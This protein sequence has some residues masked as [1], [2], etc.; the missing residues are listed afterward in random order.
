[1]KR[2]FA[3]L[4]LS[5]FLLMVPSFDG[6]VQGSS[7]YQAP[8]GVYSYLTWG[9]GTQAQ[10][11]GSTVTGFASDSGIVYIQAA[12]EGYP[13]RTIA[14]L[15]GCSAWTI[16]VPSTV[17]RI[18][19]GAFEG[20]DD[21]KIVYFLGDRPEGALP[22]DVP[23]IHLEGTSGWDG[24]DVLQLEVYES[25]GSSFD[26][27]V[28]DGKAV[29]HALLSGTEISIPSSTADGIPFRAIGD[30][31]FRDSDVTSV[32]IG[33]GVEEIGVRAFYGC[34]YLTDVVYPSTLETLRDECFRDCL[35]LTSADLPDVAFIGF[36]AFR[37]CKA[38]PYAVIPDSVATLHDGAFYLCRAVRT[39]E[40]GERITTIPPRCFGYCDSIT[41]VELPDRVTDIGRSAFYSCISLESIGL[42]N[43]RSIGDDAF[44]GCYLLGSTGDLDSVESIG[45]RAFSDCRSLDAAVLSG[46][47]ETLGREAFDGCRSL[48]TLRFLG[49]MP[50]IGDLAIPAGT[51]IVCLSSHADSWRSYD[52]KLTV[53]EVGGSGNDR[54]MIIIAMFAIILAAATLII[55][56]KAR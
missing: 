30:Q 31:A 56:R 35:R 55:I 26:Y 24:E 10:P 14:S 11:Y 39:I 38:I 28:I 6:A 17:E 13:V 42:G 7:E 4:L 1:M 9:A 41:K 52:G 33:E 45:D 48:T 21:L 22:G 8:D 40:M 51:E 53:E 2:L 47:L 12:L 54:T 25:G 44:Y 37:E 18:E 3:V 15:E 20:C 49:D 34:W 23:V 32:V 50:V 36:E 19:D 29:V 16:V 5:S 43:I 27:Y 46:S